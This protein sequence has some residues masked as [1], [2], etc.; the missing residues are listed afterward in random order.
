MPWTEISHQMEF[1]QLG[2]TVLG[3][4]HFEKTTG[5]L[6]FN[7]IMERV[8]KTTILFGESESDF[9]LII[10]LAQRLRIKVKILKEEDAEDR[11]MIY[12]MEKAKTGECVDRSAIMKSLRR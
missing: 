9:A 3:Y 10:E 7:K 4:R 6:I 11:A 2:S 12:A 1:E 8:M 5:I